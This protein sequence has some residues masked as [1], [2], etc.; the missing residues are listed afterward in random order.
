MSFLIDA[1]LESGIPQLR[2][3]DAETGVV[4]LRW[5]HASFLRT[6]DEAECQRGA[7][8]SLQC[9]FK[10]LVLLACASNFSTADGAGATDFTEMCVGCKA[11]VTDHSGTV[12]SNVVYLAT[13]RKTEKDHPI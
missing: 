9:L 8:R 1:W 13:A 10:D 7:N 12:P 2:I 5:N 3:R 6:G 11:C 4:R